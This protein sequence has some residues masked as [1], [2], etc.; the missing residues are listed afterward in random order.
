MG[1]KDHKKIWSL[2]I[3]HPLEVADLG[4]EIQLQMGKNKQ[5]TIKRQVKL[6]DWFKNKDEC[7]GPLMTI[8]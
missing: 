3:Y 7:R 5:E 8:C 1:V 4:S 2:E 6:I